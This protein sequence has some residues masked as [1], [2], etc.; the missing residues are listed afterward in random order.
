MKKLHTNIVFMKGL[1]NRFCTT[2]D[3]IGVCR[4]GAPAR[5]VVH[6]FQFGSFGLTTVNYSFEFL[7]EKCYNSFSSI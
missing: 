2:V 7:C 1:S 4:C 3:E 6:R 5:F